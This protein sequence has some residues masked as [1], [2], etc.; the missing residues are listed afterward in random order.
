MKFFIKRNR[1]KGIALFIAIIAVSAISLIIFSI[2]DIAFKEQIITYS[3]KDSK[4][5]FYAADSGLECALYHDVK[6]EGFYFASNV[7]SPQI[8]NIICNENG[9]TLTPD[10][11]YGA[12]SATTTFSFNIEWPEGYPAKSCAIVTISKNLV[13]AGPDIHTVIQSR[14]YN[15]NCGNDTPN[16]VDAGNRNLERALEVSY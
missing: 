8:G 3:G 9:I 15:N 7:S 13:G 5:A 12:Q 16:R 6:R 4:I 14:G 1:K 10:S 11:V 2:A